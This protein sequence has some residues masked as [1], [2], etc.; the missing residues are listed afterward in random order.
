MSKFPGV[1]HWRLHLQKSMHDLCSD[2]RLG[3]G[4]SE[5]SFRDCRQS[6]F[7]LH[8]QHH[9]RKFPAAS[10]GDTAQCPCQSIGLV[11]P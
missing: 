8:L 11:E 3:G 2:A 9:V 4:G 6:L 7:L 1:F 10:G 5:R